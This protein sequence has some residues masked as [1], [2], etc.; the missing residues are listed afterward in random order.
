MKIH[1]KYLYLQKAE[2]I[3]LEVRKKLKKQKKLLLL[4]YCFQKVFINVIKRIC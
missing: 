2:L 4:N 3:I 1:R